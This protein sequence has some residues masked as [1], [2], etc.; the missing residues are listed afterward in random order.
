MHEVVN[1]GEPKRLDAFLAERLSAYSRTFLQRIIEEG[2]VSVTPLEREVKSSVRVPTGALVRITIPPP[3]KSDLRPV[4]LPVK[5]LFQ[6]EHIAVIDKSPDISVHAAP[7]QTTP[8]L[9]NALLFHIH[10]LSGIGGEE[11]PGI[12]H[13]LDRETSGLLVVAK[14]DQAHQDRKSVV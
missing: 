5:I 2:L 3:R 13:R 6:D 10:D 7:G 11:R 12:V 14:H 1:R 8:T 4:D 9:V